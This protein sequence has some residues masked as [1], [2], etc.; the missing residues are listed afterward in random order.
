MDR[1][2]RRMLR[3]APNAH[4]VWTPG[5]EAVRRGHASAAAL[6]ERSTACYIV[7]MARFLEAAFPTTASSALLRMGGL[8][9]RT[10]AGYRAMSLAEQ[11][12]GEECDLRPDRIVLR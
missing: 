4:L 2:V 9:G 3:R 5:D 1:A 11:V 6:S 10:F 7:V 12:R 8:M